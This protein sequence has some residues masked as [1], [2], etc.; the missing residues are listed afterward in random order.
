MCLFVINTQTI[1]QVYN[2]TLQRYLNRPTVFQ[3]VS[4][5]RAIY[6][7]KLTVFSYFHL[8]SKNNGDFRFVLNI[9]TL[10]KYIR[11]SHFKLESLRN[12]KDVLLSNVFMCSIDLKRMLN[13]LYLSLRKEKNI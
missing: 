9:I 1:L 8:V 3:I 4:T 11:T 12:V 7:C 6:N 2:K 10:N 5:S 13:K